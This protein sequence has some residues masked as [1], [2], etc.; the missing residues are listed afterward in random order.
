LAPIF[1]DLPTGHASDTVVYPPMGSMAKDREM[2][3]HPYDHSGCVTIYLT[4]T[5]LYR[6]RHSHKATIFCMVTKLS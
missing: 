1:Q 5:C 2:S 3:T 6:K 4:Y